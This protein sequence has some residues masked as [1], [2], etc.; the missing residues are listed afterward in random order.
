MDLAYSLHPYTN[1]AVHEDRGPF[2]I[3]RGEGIYVYDDQENKYIE[4][5]A[6]LWCT[7]LGYSEKR[8]V[9]AA[10]AQMDQLPFSHSFAHRAT[11]PVIEL[12]EKMISIAQ[13]KQGLSS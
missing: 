8:L 9:D 1:L 6:G 4:G 3:T 12:S 13:F 5:L 11:V 2:V 10:K 7:G